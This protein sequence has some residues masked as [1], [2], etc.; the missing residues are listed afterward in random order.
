M[1]FRFFRKLSLAW[2]AASTPSHA[3]LDV[4]QRYYLFVV[5]HYDE[6]FVQSYNDAQPGDGMIMSLETDTLLLNSFGLL[7]HTAQ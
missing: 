5:T 6:C 7:E 2:G 3:Y 4:K 1:Y